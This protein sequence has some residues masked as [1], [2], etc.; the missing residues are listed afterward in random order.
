MEALLKRV[1]IRMSFKKSIRRIL[2]LACMAPIVPIIFWF[3][4]SEFFL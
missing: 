2:V 3:W 1:R 4:S